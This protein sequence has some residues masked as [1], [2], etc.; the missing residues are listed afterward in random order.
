MKSKNPAIQVG[1]DE[2]LLYNPLTK[3]VDV[4]DRDVMDQLSDPETLPEDILNLLKRHGHITD[5]SESEG[6]NIAF[7][8]YRAAYAHFS[9]QTQSY[10]IPTYSCNMRCTYCYEKDLRTEHRIMDS[11]ML[12]SFFEAVHASSSKDIILYG[13]EPLQKVTQPIVEQAVTRC[14]D[15]GYNLAVCTNGLELARFTHILDTFSTIMITLDGIEPVQN[16]RRPKPGK[17]DSFTAVVEAIE[18]VTERGIP[19]IISVNADAHNMDSLPAL[20]DFFISKGWHKEKNTEIMVSHIMQSLDK[21]YSHIAEPREAARKMV[22][23]YRTF[24]QME[25][26]LPSIK[27]SNPLVSVFFEGEEWRPKYWYCGAN[28]YMFF[29]DPYG[30]IYTCYMVIG[31]QQFA[32][33]TYY[34]TLEFFPSLKTWRGRNCFSI[35]QCRECSFRYVC[36]GGCA[37]RQYLRTGSFSD[38]YCDVVEGLAESYVPFLYER[39]KEKGG[40]L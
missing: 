32:A 30:F 38:P 18:Y 37:Y 15:M 34:E 23:L 6:E 35:P 4:V 9:A 2:F 27:G 16:T 40:R 26:F 1:E 11:R 7:E 13:G 17:K 19:L 31:R 33:G 5:T 39:M 20:A 12:D 3:I 14:E 8:E 21:K 22:E 36:G 29:Y 10:L 28:C 25:I 24:P